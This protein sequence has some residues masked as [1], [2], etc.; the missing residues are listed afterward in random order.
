M[1]LAGGRATRMGGGDKP[2]LPLG[3]RPMLA[4]VLDRLRPQAGPVA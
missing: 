2:L 4:H 3:G 1:I